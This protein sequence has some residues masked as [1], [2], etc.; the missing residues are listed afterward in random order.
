[1]SGGIVTAVKPLEITGGRAMAKTNIAELKRAI[2]A[3]E[4][5]RGQ[6]PTVQRPDTA[7]NPKLL[8]S[9]Q[10]GAQ[11]LQEFFSKAGLDTEKLL[12]L[13]KQFGTDLRAA[14]DKQKADAVK[15]AAG[16]KDTVHSSTR[17]QREALELLSNSRPFFPFPLITLEKPFLILSSPHS[18]LLSGSNIEP[19][20]SWAKIRVKSSADEGSE[21]VSF[22]YMWTN[23]SDFYTVINATASMSATGYLEATATGG[24]TGIDPTSR[25]SSVGGSANISLWPWWQPYPTPTPEVTQ[26]LPGVGTY[27]DFWDETVSTTVSDGYT[28]TQTQFVVP[29]KGVVIVEAFFKIGYSNG[30]GH[31]DADFE[32]GDFKL[33]CPVSVISILSGTVTSMGSASM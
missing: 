2:I 29:P 11:L 19:F 31:V 17:S 28:V 16:A 30:H 20:N 7:G 25:H 14:A 13:Q 10:A 9:R 22:Y 6:V 5:R 21:K 18:N 33:G 27:A 32:S 23:D 1:M 8:K 4:E 12:A 24:W 15:R 3:A 26:Y